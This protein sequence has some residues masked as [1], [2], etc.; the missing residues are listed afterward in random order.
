MVLGT[1][2]FTADV[3]A[4]SRFGNAATRLLFTL[5]TGERLSDTQTGLCGYPA[6]MIP[7]LRSVRGERYEYELNLLLEAKQAGYFIHTVDIAMVYLD[8]NSGSHFRPLADS[9][10][11]CSPAQIP[12]LV[13]HGVSGGHRGVPAPDAGHR[14]AAARRA[15]CPGGEF[16]RELPGGAAAVP[17]LNG[18]SPRGECGPSCSLKRSP[19][20]SPEG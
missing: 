15:G 5:A 2:N 8:H 19:A 14:F 18:P 3:P 12:G 7:W 13:L 9:A 4:R 1:R 16:G 11:I 6:A 17:L 10:R 20:T